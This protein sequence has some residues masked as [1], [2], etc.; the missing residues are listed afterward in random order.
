MLIVRDRQ[1]GSRNSVENI[2]SARER[3]MNS[4]M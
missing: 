1:N 3:S 2:R 4:R